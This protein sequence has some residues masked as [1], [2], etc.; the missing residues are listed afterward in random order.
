M[1][2][3][4]SRRTAAASSVSRKRSPSSPSC[5]EPSET[6]S[7]SPMRYTPELLHKK[8]FIF[9]EAPRWFRDAFY[10]CDIDA[11]CIYRLA[12]DGTPQFIYKHGSPVSGWI[13]RD[14][15]SLLVVA[16]IE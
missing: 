16:G 10:C 11:G 4:R 8:P 7:G 1:R 2:G 13:Q 9:P 15:G 3:P 6:R 5:N 12:A 14:D